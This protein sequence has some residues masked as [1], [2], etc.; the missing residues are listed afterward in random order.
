MQQILKQRWTVLTICDPRGERQVSVF[1]NELGPRT[2]DFTQTMAI[3]QQTANSGPPR[4][5][6]K[7]RRVADDVFEL[8]T[9]SGVR[10]PFFYDAGNI[11]ICTEPMHKPKKTELKRVIERA[12]RVRRSYFEAKRRNEIEV[13]EGEA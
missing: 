6:K 4:N 5:V 11:V 9:R 13:I 10:V 2:A 8:K 7:C 3:L 12:E 1:I